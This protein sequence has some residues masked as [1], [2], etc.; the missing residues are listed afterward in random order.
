MGTLGTGTAAAQPASAMLKYTCTFPTIGGQPITAT[1]ST[2]IPTSITVGQ[3]SRPFAITAAAAVNTGFALGLRYVLGVS[4]IEGTLDAGTTVT[5]P[6]GDI[7]VPVHLTIARTGIPT[8]SFNIPATGTAPTLSF[9]KPGSARITAGDFTLH[10][11]PED[12][13]GNITR[14]G[15]VNVP[16]KLN[17]GQ[18]NV[19]TS[20]D[21]T[22]TQ[23]A[24]GSAPSETPGTRTA[25]AGKPTAPATA[26]P[27]TTGSATP[28]GSGT[29]TAGPST[30]A[31][32]GPTGSTINAAA[33]STTTSGGHDTWSLIL[34]AAGILT[35]GAAAFR[36]GP[37]LKRRRRAGDDG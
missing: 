29:A 14:L 23:A 31:A 9:S 16:C 28:D 20:F 10:L 1:I 36:F 35:A 19:V 8:G 34:L 33:T 6:Q 4:I 26:T 21:I 3:S 5:A 27:T 22:G 7:R 30:I 17:T 15:R 37:Q 24:P 18:N 12:A 32:P 2:D 13:N 11:I 25:S